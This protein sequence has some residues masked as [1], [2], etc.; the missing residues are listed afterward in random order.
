MKR[1]VVLTRTTI[2]TAVGVAAYV[3][4]HLGVGL[5]PAVQ[6]QV[7]DVLSWTLPVAIPL[8]SALWARIGVTPVF[9]PQSAVAVPLVPATPLVGGAPVDL[10]QI[11][12]GSQE[13]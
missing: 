1:E 3:L 8:L 13:G 2:V 5:T 12:N 4:A 11:L 10:D 6:Q 7:V 9:D